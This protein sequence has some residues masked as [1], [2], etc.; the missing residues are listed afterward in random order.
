MR[1]TD[2]EIMQQA[3]ERMTGAPDA[4]TNPVF[5]QSRNGFIQGWEAAMVARQEQEPVAWIERVGGGVSYDLYHNIA[6]ELPEGFRSDLYTAPQPAQQPL[7]D[8]MAE[9]I[10]GLAMAL[11]DAVLIRIGMDDE[12]TRQAIRRIDNLAAKYTGEA[13]HGIGEKK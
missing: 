13:A 4:W 1:R 12:A 10:N 9:L 5:M 6:R 2:R 3:F 7:T 11:H 8:E